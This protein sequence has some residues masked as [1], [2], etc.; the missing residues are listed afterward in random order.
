MG[1]V[2]E[3]PG[4]FSERSWKVMEFLGCVMGDRHNDAGADAE[5]C[6]N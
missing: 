2:L 3:R 6:K 4:N 1:L 5:V